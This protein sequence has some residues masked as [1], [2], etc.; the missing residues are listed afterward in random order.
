MFLIWPLSRS[1]V[2]KTLISILMA[3]CVIASGLGIPK[4]YYVLT[5]DF[6]NPDHYYLLIPEFFWCRMEEAVV[7]IAACAP[8]LKSPVERFLRRLGLPGF[9]TPTREM[10][11]ISD[12]SYDSN[13]EPDSWQGSENSE[14]TQEEGAV[15]KATTMTTTTETTT[16]SQR[17]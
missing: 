13:K 12:G 2:E 8:L 1:V 15:G 17:T 6:G 14:R 9:Q 11:A 3:S 10:N 16:E 4:I 7:I 5:F